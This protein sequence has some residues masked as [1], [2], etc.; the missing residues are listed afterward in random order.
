VKKVNSRETVRR[1][2]SSNNSGIDTAD[3]AIVGTAAAGSSNAVIDLVA[4]VVSR[5]DLAVGGRSSN[6]SNSNSGS[7]GGGGGGEA[8]IQRLLYIANKHPQTTVQLDCYRAIAHTCLRN[9]NFQRYRQ[10]IGP[11]GS[12]V[13]SSSL[14]LQQQQQQE[15]V[16]SYNANWVAEQETVYRQ[17][18][19]VLQHRLQAAQSQLHKVRA[20]FDVVCLSGTKIQTYR[21]F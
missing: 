17:G 9:G 5:Y 19:D 18:R 12:M 8:G 2:M 13:A 20:F 21:G 11:G 3:H 4:S 1:E 6:I 15:F 7:T 14:M 10:V 16:L